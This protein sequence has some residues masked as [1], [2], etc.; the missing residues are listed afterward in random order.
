MSD[1]ILC[2]CHFSLVAGSCGASFN[3]LIE[4]TDGYDDAKKDILWAFCVYRETLI[5]KFTAV[6]YKFNIS[7]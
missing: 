3:Y 5:L 1:A 6:T 4:H 7:S 2:K